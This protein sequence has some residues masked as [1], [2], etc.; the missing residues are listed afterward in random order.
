MPEKS[1]HAAHAQLAASR[2]PLGLLF[3]VDRTAGGRE[4]DDEGDQV[5]GGDGGD[6]FR[7]VVVF[8]NRRLRYYILDVRF[9]PVAVPLVVVGAVV[10]SIGNGA[11][12]ALA[13]LGDSVFLVGPE[14][15]VLAGLEERPNESFG[16]DVAGDSD[17]V[18]LQ[19]YLRRINPCT[20]ASSNHHS[21]W[22]LQISSSNYDARN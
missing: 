19:I 11:G 3:A 9:R 18:L 17:L 13:R 5:D 2:H 15:G 7:K 6:I 8:P 10:G 21:R 14:L 4:S 1:I 20:S 22:T 16:V 12:G